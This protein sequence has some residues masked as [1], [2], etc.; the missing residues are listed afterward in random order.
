MELGLPIYINSTKTCQTWSIDGFD[1]EWTVGDLLRKVTRQVGVEVKT[2]SHRGNLL[3]GPRFQMETDLGACG[4]GKAAP[5]LTLSPD[6]DQALEALRTEA[7]AAEAAAWA[8]EEESEEEATPAPRSPHAIKPPPM[9]DTGGSGGGAVGGRAELQP[10]GEME[11]LCS[12]T[13]LLFIDPLNNNHDNPAIFNN[14]GWRH[15]SANLPQQL[16]ITAAEG[17]SRGQKRTSTGASVGTSKPRSKGRGGTPTARIK[18]REQKTLT[19]ALRAREALR[20]QD[21]I[22]LQPLHEPHGVQ[23]ALVAA[24]HKLRIYASPAHGDRQCHKLLAAYRAQHVPQLHPV[25]EPHLVDELLG[26]GG[27]TNRDMRVLGRVD[28][29][30][31]PFMTTGG[32]ANLGL[33][34]AALSGNAKD[35]VTSI[36]KVF[37][38]PSRRPHKS[39]VVKT[40][41]YNGLIATLARLRPQSSRLTSTDVRV[42]FYFNYLI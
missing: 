13:S 7:A 17:K 30:G 20:R 6:T 37:G 18:E 36:G 12:R 42:L 25:D 15:L 5:Y 1:P 21:T 14:E 23:A 22:A 8:A 2:V 33:H 40:Q 10:E 11:Q 27:G 16:E 26:P 29:S 34:Y 31:C 19:Q 24:V 4:V 41:C 9:D 3:P 39:R 38:G 32:L 28:W 35:V